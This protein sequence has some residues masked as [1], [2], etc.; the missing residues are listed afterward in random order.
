[1]LGTLARK[2]WLQITGEKSTGPIEGLDLEVASPRALKEKEILHWCGLQWQGRGISCFKADKISNHWLKNPWT[3]LMTESEFILAL[4]TRTKTFPSISSR[5]AASIPRCRLCS[6]GP[7]SLGHIIC[8]CPSLKDIRMARHNTICTILIREASA[9]GWT[10]LSEP[11]LMTRDESGEDTLF[12]MEFFK[13]GK[14]FPFPEQ[15]RLLHSS[16]QTVRVW[17]FPLGA[18]GKWH[19]PNSSLLRALGV[20]EARLVPLARKIV[21]RSIFGTLRICKT[22]NSLVSSGGK[23]PHSEGQ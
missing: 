11:K 9:L 19:G 8:A 6:R 4:K 15:V 1:M 13:R 2:L 12:E 17:G 7:E 14:Y 23:E 10:C 18:R 5:T 21:M 22:F 3:G 20:P 16:I